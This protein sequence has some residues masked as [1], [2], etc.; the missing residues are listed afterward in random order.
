MSQ[1]KLGG[2]SK[3]G[4]LVE[5]V[6]LYLGF[7]WP[8]EQEPYYP[9]QVQP[10]STLN[11]VPPDPVDFPLSQTREPPHHSTKGGSKQKPQC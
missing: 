1:N 7:D 11:V 5:N 9:Q 2:H 8:E 10:N 4:K 6:R 3:I